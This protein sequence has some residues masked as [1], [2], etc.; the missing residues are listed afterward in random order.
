MESS[1]PYFIK[2]LSTKSSSASLSGS[3]FIQGSRGSFD[4]GGIWP[5]VQGRLEQRGM[6][7]NWLAVLGET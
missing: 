5:G 2:M 6:K 7:S 4:L 1:L 3:V